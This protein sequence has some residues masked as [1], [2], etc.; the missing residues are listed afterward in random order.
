MEPG[1]TNGKMEESTKESID[2]TRNTGLANTHGQMAA[3]TTGSGSIVKGMARVR[4]LT[5]T[6]ALEKVSGTMISVSDGQAKILAHLR[7][8]IWG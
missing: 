2:L 1:Y 8:E 6:A 3:D 5:S 4:L 7:M